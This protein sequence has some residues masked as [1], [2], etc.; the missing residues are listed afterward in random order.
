MFVS[1]TDQNIIYR[2]G[3]QLLDSGSD[4][5][6]WDKWEPMT[7]D[8]IDIQSENVLTEWFDENVWK[9]S[10]ILQ[11]HRSKSVQIPEFQVPQPWVK[12]NSFS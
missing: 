5:W 8:V 11:P 6:S 2:K 9:V 1:W 10:I 7:S 12:V 3:K 4:I